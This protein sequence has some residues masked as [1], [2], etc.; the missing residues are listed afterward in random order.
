MEPLRGD[1]SGQRP[2]YRLRDQR[3][4]DLEATGNFVKKVMIPIAL[5]SLFTIAVATW[6]DWSF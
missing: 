5:S 6:L 3:D 1:H 4:A 2:G